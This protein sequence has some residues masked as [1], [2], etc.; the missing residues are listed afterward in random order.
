[1]NCINIKSQEFQELLEAS[2]LP[3]LLLEMR[4]AKWQDKNGLDKFPTIDELQSSNEVNTTLKAV[5]ILQSDKAK[6]VFEKGKKANWDLNKILTELQIPKDQ[7]QLL[8]DLDIKDREQIALELASNYSYS[9]EIN[10]TQELDKPGLY[11]KQ[12]NY[13]LIPDTDLPAITESVYNTNGDLIAD[14][15]SKEEAEAYIEKYQAKNTNTQHYSNL[16]VPGGTNYTENEIATPLITPSIKGHA[17][18]ATDNGIGWHR[19]DDR[20]IDIQQM[21]KSSLIK[22]VPCK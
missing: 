19:S 5:N 8:L 15:N 14:F 6:Q 7:K 12:D 16:T 22:E 9:V 3:S 13:G 1:M 21:L 18:F 11:Y 10:T 20:V 4:V 17:Q 2:K